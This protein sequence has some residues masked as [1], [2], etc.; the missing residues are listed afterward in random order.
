MVKEIIIDY[1]AIVNQQLGQR[2]SAWEKKIF[3]VRFDFWFLGIISHEI[4]HFFTRN[5]KHH[6]HKSNTK[7]VYKE[8]SKNVTCPDN[9]VQY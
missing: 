3:E 9:L 8:F 1:F 6:F 4:T 2:S 7:R 5:Y